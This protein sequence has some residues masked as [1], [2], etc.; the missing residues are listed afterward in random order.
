MIRVAVDMEKH[1]T[2]AFKK[3]KNPK[4]EMA[5]ANLLISPLLEEELLIDTW[6]QTMIFRGGDGKQFKR[7]VQVFSIIGPAGDAYLAFSTNDEDIY[8]IEYPSP[9]YYNDV[10]NR[11]VKWTTADEY[12]LSEEEYKKL[13]AEAQRKQQEFAAQGAM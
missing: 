6:T 2:N 12:S 1:V 5:K 13:I 11:A 8:Y 3:L 10:V 9:D 4:R 7:G